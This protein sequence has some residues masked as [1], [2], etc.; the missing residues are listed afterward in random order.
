MYRIKYKYWEAP[1]HIKLPDNYWPGKIDS[2][3]LPYVM[4]E[5]EELQ[6]MGFLVE[7]QKV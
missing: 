3:N 2:D 4:N 1:E 7:L 5:I 6:E